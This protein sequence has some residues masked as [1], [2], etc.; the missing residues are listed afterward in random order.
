[1]LIERADTALERKPKRPAGATKRS[2]VRAH[3]FQDAVGPFPRHQE[4]VP[5]SEIK[6]IPEPYRFLNADDSLLLKQLERAGKEPASEVLHSF[7][8]SPRRAT[9]FRFCAN[10][11]KIVA[12]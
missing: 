9:L 8:S 4:R 3:D 2:A 7:F 1:L 10:Q 6:A 12:F 5:R 11:R